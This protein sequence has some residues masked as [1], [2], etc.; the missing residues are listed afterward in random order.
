MTPRAAEHP[1]PLAAVVIPTL[2]PEYE[3]LSSLAELVLSAG[4]PVAVI[5]DGS[6][7]AE[8][9][10]STLPAG[11]H[12][13]SLGERRG[14]AAALNAGL[15]W[16]V[17]IGARSVITLDQ[18]THATSEYLASLVDYWDSLMARG[19]AVGAVGPDHLG[20]FAHHPRDAGGMAVVD[21]VAQSGALFST[22]ALVRIGGFDESLAVDGVDA[23][24]CLRL[25][26]A[27]LPTVVMPATLDH[28]IGSGR[29]V[30]VG[31]RAILISDHSPRRR[32]TITRNRLRLLG[33]YGGHHPR[34]AALTLRRLAVG[35]ALAVTAEAD[36]GA[37][38]RAVA[39]GLVDALTGR[40]GLPR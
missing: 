7:G 1:R 25:A 8:T 3:A 19:R 24:A 14:Q 39:G 37:K 30:S 6:Q 26:A 10:R 40:T 29:T 4:L 20:P 15:R 5:D 18:D 12:W 28:A 11:V 9:V 33:R 2:N 31:D 22:E 17:S 16:A 35:S 21:E 38:A 23:D 13:I 32:R 27:G 34:W 36:R